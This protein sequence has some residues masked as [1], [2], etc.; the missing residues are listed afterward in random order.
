MTAPAHGV[1]VCVLQTQRDET[2]GGAVSGRMRWHLLLT[3]MSTQYVHTH[4]LGLNGFVCRAQIG[5]DSPAAN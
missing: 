5:D 2:M 3:H 4:T 1:R